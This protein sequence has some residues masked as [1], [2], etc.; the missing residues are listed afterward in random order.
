MIRYL[1]LLAAAAMLA[2]CGSSGSS[3][4]LGGAAP[5]AMVPIASAPVAVHR[6]YRIG[7]G[8]QLN[9][10]V[11][12]VEDLTKEKIPVDAAGQ[13][14]LPLIGAVAASGRTTTELAND[15]ATRLEEKYLQDPQVSVTV[16]QAAS[17]K[18]TVDGAVTEA[19]VF[20]LQ[21]RTTLLQAVAMAKGP[22]ADANLQRVAVFRTVNGQRMAAMFDLK[23]IR[24]GAA[25]D[26]EI[27]GDDIVVV[28]SSALKGAWREVLRA[29][30]AFS[31]FR[32]F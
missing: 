15:I 9:V 8:D 29:L 25:A 32:P 30:P 26:P 24:R 19:G 18:V 27:L 13:I 17:Q 16:A 1:L 11:F 10:N 5:G 28:D 3:S 21:G 14:Q 4:A 2:A 20:E 7:I 23:E 31:I 6:D 22:R 12:Q